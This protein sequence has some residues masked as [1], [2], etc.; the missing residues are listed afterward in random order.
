MYSVQI[1]NLYSL[2]LISW[3][4]L[5]WGDRRHQLVLQT[6]T[7]K[8]FVSVPSCSGS[9]AANARTTTVAA[10]TTANPS[11]TSVYPGQWTDDGWAASS[12]A[13]DQLPEGVKTCSRQFLF[14]LGWHLTVC[15]QQFIFVYSITSY[16]VCLINEAAFWYKSTFFAFRCCL[17]FDF[18]VIII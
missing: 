4:Y 6:N 16:N 8:S 15:L 14:F 17:Q 13:N 1:F 18:V 3:P 7:I 2:I 11:T 12:T 10:A 9:S 5:Q